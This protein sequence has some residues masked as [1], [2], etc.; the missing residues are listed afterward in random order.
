MQPPPV[1][2]VIRLFYITIVFI[3]GIKYVSLRLVILR[4]SIFMLHTG[5]SDVSHIYAVRFHYYEGSLNLPVLNTKRS[6]GGR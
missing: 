2:M 3:L 1:N 5:R 6:G 4:V